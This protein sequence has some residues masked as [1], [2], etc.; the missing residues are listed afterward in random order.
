MQSSAP[1]ISPPPRWT[2]GLDKVPHDGEDDDGDG[3]Q[4][5]QGH[6]PGAFSGVAHVE[7]PINERNQDQHGDGDLLG[8]D[9]HDLR[10]PCAHEVGIF[11]QPQ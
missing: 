11:R 3:R 9:A 4:S 6:G 10:R 1:G 8:N 5:A 2:E 7:V